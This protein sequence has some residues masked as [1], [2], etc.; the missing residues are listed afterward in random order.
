MKKYYPVFVSKDGELKSLS[1]LYPEVKRDICPILRVLSK[2]ESKILKYI[3]EWNFSDNE[4]F[5]DFSL[6]NDMAAD[7][8]S[9]MLSFLLAAKVN[10]V[11]VVEKN[12]RKSYLKVVSNLI[13]AGTVSSVCIK[14][15]IDTKKEDVE[16]NAAFLIEKLDITRSQCSIWIDMSV[17]ESGLVNGHFSNVKS[18]ITALANNAEYENIIVTSS[19]FPIDMTRL[20]ADKVHRLSRYEWKLWE[21]LKVQDGLPKNLRYGDYGTKYPIHRD[22]GFLGSCSVK[23][24][25]PEIY[26]IYRG[27]KPNDHPEG[28]GQYVLHAKK[29]VKTKE[30][31]GSDF[32]WGDEKVEFFAGQNLKDKKAKKGS[33][34]S[35]VEI[36]QNHHTSL[37]VSMI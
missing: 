13:L 21:L 29:L 28:N 5:F 27:H 6:A 17:I 10:I 30:Y 26:L 36:S 19:S 11:P 4:I 32:S 18:K 9:N 33:A 16:S 23:Y 2:E 35:W 24:T 15:D 20:E 37:M 22:G 1:M 3:S 8:I 25:T 12:S 34:R 31:S 14:Y 7:D